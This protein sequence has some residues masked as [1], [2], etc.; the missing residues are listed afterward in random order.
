MLLAQT[1]KDGVYHAYTEHVAEKVT[2]PLKTLLAGNT[3]C[4]V[5]AVLVVDTEGPNQLHILERCRRGL[6]CGN[7]LAIGVK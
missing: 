4:G 7:C 6:I 1:H 3:R 2:D 5:G